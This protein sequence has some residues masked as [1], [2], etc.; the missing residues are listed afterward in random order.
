MQQKIDPY[1][2]LKTAKKENGNKEQ[3]L[4]SAKTLKS[5]IPKFVLGNICHTAC[6]QSVNT[7]TPQHKNVKKQKI[8]QKIL[9]NI[10]VKTGLSKFQVSSVKINPNGEL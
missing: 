2:L 3:N 1:G 7:T 10:S 4:N 9:P 6:L 8:K 5:K